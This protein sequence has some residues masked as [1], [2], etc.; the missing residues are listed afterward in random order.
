[1][2]GGHPKAKG[3]KGTCKGNGESGGFPPFHDTCTRKTSA[4][5][6]SDSSTVGVVAT[7]L[8]WRS[9]G[10]RGTDLYSFHRRGSGLRAKGRKEEWVISRRG[11]RG[12]RKEG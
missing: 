5:V 7:E 6:D 2:R 8:L 1:M 3:H 9:R 12:G 11:W 4:V 10:G